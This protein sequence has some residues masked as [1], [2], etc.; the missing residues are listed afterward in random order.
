MPYT[1]QTVWSA[2]QAAKEARHD[3]GRVRLRDPARIEE[4]AQAAGQPGAKVI[5]GGQSLLSPTAAP[6]AADTSW[7]SGASSAGRH[8]IH[9]GRR[10]EIGAMTTY[11]GGPAAPA[12]MGPRRCRE[13]R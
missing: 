12:R 11:A 10:A 3:P 8:L 6:R 9:G 2:I 5:A 7:T 13:H 4:A 1:P